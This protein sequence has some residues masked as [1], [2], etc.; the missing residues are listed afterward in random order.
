MC[1]RFQINL[2]SERLEQRFKARFEASPYNPHYNI[3]PS[4]I[5]PVILND[6]KTVFQ[7]IKWGLKPSWMKKGFSSSGM[8]NARAESITEKPMFRKSFE[9][10]R[11]IIPSTGFYEW[12]KTE[13]GAKIPYYIGLKDK[14]PFAFAGIWSDNK[15]ENGETVREFAIITTEPNSLT[16]KIHNRMPVILYE[17][18]EEEWL[19]EENLTIV[20]K[21]MKPYD[22]KDMEAF[23]ISPRINNP[24]YN[25]PMAINPL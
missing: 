15:D 18:D 3:S 2:D 21:L 14:K 1:G 5:V 6:D 22:A 4:A 25:D 11:C 10:R 16:K 12:Q 8:I 24:K 7:M 19:E 13:K 9:E 23:K 17:D 20:T